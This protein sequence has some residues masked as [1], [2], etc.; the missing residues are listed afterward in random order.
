MW[1]FKTKGEETEQS[2]MDKMI[3]RGMNEEREYQFRVAKRLGMYALG[4]YTQ[5][6]DA[7]LTRIEKLEHNS[8]PTAHG[9]E[10]EGA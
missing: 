8:K 1:P 7:L 9:D 4:T 3:E 10:L 2:K 6:I 5:N